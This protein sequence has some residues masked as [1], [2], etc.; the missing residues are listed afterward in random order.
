MMP[1]ARTTAETAIVEWHRHRRFGGVACRALNGDSA[2]LVDRR[3]AGVAKNISSAGGTP[4]AVE[5]ATQP[6]SIYCSSPVCGSSKRLNGRRKAHCNARGECWSWHR[7]KRTGSKGRPKCRGDA[8]GS[9]AN[10]VPHPLVQEPVPPDAVAPYRTPSISTR[11]P[12]PMG[13][14]PS[15]QLGY[16]GQ[17]V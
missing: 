16:C 5:F 8:Q 9:M 13:D 15:V 17:N 3:H 14:A 12:L 2:V 1:S 7:K 4:H 11:L 10:T 6:R